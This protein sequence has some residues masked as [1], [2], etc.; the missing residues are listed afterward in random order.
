MGLDELND[1]GRVIGERARN[2][3]ERRAESILD[4]IRFDK[5]IKGKWRAPSSS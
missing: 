1:R 3:L 2:E 5:Q 4:I